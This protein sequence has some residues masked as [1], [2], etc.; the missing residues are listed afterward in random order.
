MKRLFAEGCRG[1]V[2]SNGNVQAR[3]L[4]S[5]EC[6]E[7]TNVAK[8]RMFSERMPRANVFDVFNYE[9]GTTHCVINS[10]NQSL[11]NQ[12]FRLIRRIDH[13]R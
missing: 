2:L 10:S 7:A 11:C 6:C 13:L 3:M 5:N 12:S 1:P 8:Q 4:R 9:V